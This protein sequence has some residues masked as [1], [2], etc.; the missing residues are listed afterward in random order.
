MKQ[1]MSG[2]VKAKRN[3]TFLLASN[4]S[5]RN[6]ETHKHIPQGSLGVVAHDYGDG[7]VVV[8]FGKDL[9]TCHP[10]DL[11]LDYGD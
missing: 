6:R 9:V 7:E 10:D 5:R 1:K 4:D 11:E 3:I 8:D 2:R